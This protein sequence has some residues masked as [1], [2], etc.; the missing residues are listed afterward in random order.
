MEKEKQMEKQ[1]DMQ[2]EISPI[3][4]VLL[5]EETGVQGEEKP[6]RIF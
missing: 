2:R 1:K 4:N 5:M 3:S 6:N